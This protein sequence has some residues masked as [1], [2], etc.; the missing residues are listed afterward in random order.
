MA[1]APGAVR[2]GLRATLGVERRTRSSAVAASAGGGGNGRGRRGG[3]EGRKRREDAALEA[4]V[5]RTRE[6]L[7]FV[8]QLKCYTVQ[9]VG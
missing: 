2:I 9:T 7:F 6:F 1:A 3:S 4:S 8:Y 5:E